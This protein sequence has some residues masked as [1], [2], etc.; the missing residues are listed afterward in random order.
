MRFQIP[1]FKLTF[2]RDE[3]NAS[4]TSRGLP[5]PLDYSSDFSTDS[6]HDLIIL[7]I[8][9]CSTYNGDD[10]GTIASENHSHLGNEA[11]D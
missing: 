1:G 7:I 9:G 6:F 8:F 4:V 11:A 10:K 2:Y 5:T 3:K